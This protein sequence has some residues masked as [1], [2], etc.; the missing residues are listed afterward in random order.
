MGAPARNKV[1]WTRRSSFFEALPVDSFTPEEETLREA[2][3]DYIHKWSGK[4]PPLLSH[5]GSDSRIK[6]LKDRVLPKGTPVNFKEWIDRRIGGEI[7]F[8]EAPS[9]L[10]HFGLQGQLDHSAIR[11]KRAEGEHTNVSAWKRG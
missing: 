8:V 4:V 11:G 10:V 9:G 6:V 2:L 5:A 1:R 3:L 7:E